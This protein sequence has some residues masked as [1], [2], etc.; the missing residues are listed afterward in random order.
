MVVHLMD[1]LGILTLVSTMDE[2]VILVLINCS[3]ILALIFWTTVGILT[4]YNFFDG[5]FY[6]WMP[7]MSH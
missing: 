2:L 3:L 6:Y 4:V 1:D 5:N 7:F